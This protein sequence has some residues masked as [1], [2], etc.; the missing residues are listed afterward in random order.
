MSSLSQKIK[1][2][3][4][5]RKKEYSIKLINEFI[6]TD[7]FSKNPDLESFF[8]KESEEKKKIQKELLQ[9]YKKGTLPNNR[10]VSLKERESSFFILLVILIEQE[11]KKEVES[12][13]SFKQKNNKK[14]QAKGISPKKNEDRL[15]SSIQQ[16]NIYTK[17]G[18]RFLK[19]EANKQPL[20]KKK[21]ISNFSKSAT[22]IA[23][24]MFSIQSKTS[25][26]QFAQDN[27]KN[28]NDFSRRTVLEKF[29]EMVR[30]E[31]IISNNT[32]S[33]K[34]PPK[35]KEFFAQSKSI[36]SKKENVKYSPI[37]DFLSKEQ[38]QELG[39]DKIEKI[40][41]T[42]N[43]RASKFEGTITDIYKEIHKKNKLP[44]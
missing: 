30:L 37:K 21:K 42:L 26:I 23:S 38:I 24:L 29:P 36:F 17:T 32:N 15:F 16:Y 41:T 11:E 18:A 7:P 33:E 9:I 31:T 14:I 2:A 10:K 1:E 35:I 39:L 6:E 8:E 12:L 3:E 20:D 27:P 28:F 40:D 43:E 19:K 34:T 4:E 13:L 25:L 22:E 44:K 5:L